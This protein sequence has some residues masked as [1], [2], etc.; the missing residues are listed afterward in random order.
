MF[1]TRT[2]KLL[3]TLRDVK[4]PHAM[5]YFP[6]SK[7]LWVVNGGDGT[8]KIFDTNTYALAD[9]IKLTPAADS[10]VYDAASTCFT[11]LPAARMRR[12]SFR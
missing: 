10:A 5:V 2:N 3:R 11:L 12:W 8:L 9:T 1:D 7:Q 4:A 6:D